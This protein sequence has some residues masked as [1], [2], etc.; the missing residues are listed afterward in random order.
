MIAVMEG[1]ARSRISFRKVEVSG[2]S[3]QVLRGQFFKTDFTSSLDS[4]WKF[5]KYN[6]AN[7]SVGHFHLTH[8]NFFLIFVILKVKKSKKYDESWSGEAAGKAGVEFFPSTSSAARKS[9]L[10]DSTEE[11]LF[12]IRSWE[13]V[14]LNNT[15]F[16]SQIESDIEKLLDLFGG[17]R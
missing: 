9:S 12:R 14:C 2:S 17:G 6:P 7:L 3:S 1:R 13:D 11:N 15:S 4:A 8:Q 10:Q 5:D 16:I